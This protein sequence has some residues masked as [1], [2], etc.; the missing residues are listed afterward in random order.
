[1]AGL[2]KDEPL[3]LRQLAHELRESARGAAWPGYAEKL[4]EAA[5]QLE[6]RAVEI[7]GS[8]FLEKRP[9]R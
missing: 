6:Q 1:M 8:A 4:I 2:E 7:E 3:R 5:E 9:T